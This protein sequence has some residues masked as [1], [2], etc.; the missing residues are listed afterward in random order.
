MKNSALLLLLI[1]IFLAYMVPGA[2]FAQATVLPGYSNSSMSRFRVVLDPGHGGKDSVTR[3]D[4]YQEKDIVLSISRELKNHLEESGFEVVMTRET[5][6]FIS[7]PARAAFKGDIFISIHANTV[8]DTIGPSVREMIKGMEIYTSNRMEYGAELL[9]K[10]KV[11]ATAFEKQ[12]RNLKGIQMR[13]LKAKSLAVLD[14]NESPAI[15]IELG[16]LSNKE[17]LAFLINRDNYKH[18]AEAFVRSIKAYQSMI[19][20]E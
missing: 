3:A 4:N 17:D 11:L 18:I 5:D 7:L 9:D 16:F 14:K 20:T 13:R 6:E 19:E 1:T 8:P 10:S 12:L 15:L 2:G